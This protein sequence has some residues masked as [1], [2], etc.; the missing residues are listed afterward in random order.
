[1]SNQ[2]SLN[3]HRPLSDGVLIRLTKVYSGS[4]GGDAGRTVDNEAGQRHVSMDD[5]G[6]NLWGAVVDLHVV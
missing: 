1:M 2:Y 6:L 3:A 5:G 4:D